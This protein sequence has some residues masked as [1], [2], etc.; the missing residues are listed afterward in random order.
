M[1]IRHCEDYRERRRAAY[2]SLGDQ[3]DAVAKLGQALVD[4]GVNV[5]QEVLDW[6][7]KVG[8]VKTQYRK[9]T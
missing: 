9:P 3:L 5:P 7:A 4:Q 1:K 8:D 6:L 2:P